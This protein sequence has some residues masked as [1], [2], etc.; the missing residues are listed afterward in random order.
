MKVDIII[1]CHNRKPKTLR[2]LDCLFQAV[3]A[4]NSRHAE[5]ITSHVYLTDD[6]C[7]DGTAQSV[8]S[9]FSNHHITIVSGD[10]NL[11]WAGGMRKAWQQAIHDHQDSDFFLLANDDTYALPSLFDELL[12]AHRFCLSHYNACGIYSGVTCEPENTDIISYSG[13]RYDAKGRLSRLNPTGE[14]QRV[15]ITNA[16]M[17]LV[18][19]Q[20]VDDIGIFYSGYLHGAAD[21]DYALQANRHGHPAL[22]TSHACALCTYD[23]TPEREVCKTLAAMTL[24]ERKRYFANPVHSDH[25][26]LVMIKRNFPKRYPLTWIVRKIRFYLPQLYFKINQIRGIY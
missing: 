16:N 19:R 13:D 15:D 3:D 26:Y 8:I 2:C 12:E 6:G 20:V 1:T 17:L 10:G 23:H 22:I 7:T 4:Y 18:P 5:P 24:K 25:D 11:Y 9:R 21:N 14:P